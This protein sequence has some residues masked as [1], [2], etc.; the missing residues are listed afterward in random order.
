MKTAFFIKQLYYAA[1][2]NASILNYY[3]RLEDIL[4]GIPAEDR[5]RILFTAYTFSFVDGWLN[6]AIE[7]QLEI[8]KLREIG[9]DSGYA[10]YYADRYIPYKLSIKT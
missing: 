2:S 9:F 1:K 5:S 4:D 7:L 3:D 8:N 10:I 6:P